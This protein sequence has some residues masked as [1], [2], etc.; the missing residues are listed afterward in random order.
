MPKHKL[1]HTLCSVHIELIPT[2]RTFMK[3]MNFHSSR[4]NLSYLALNY[5]S[6]FLTGKKLHNVQLQLKCHL[7]EKSSLYQ[8]QRIPS[9][10]LTQYFAYYILIF[11]VEEFSAPFPRYEMK[12][13]QEGHGTVLK[14]PNTFLKR[15]RY[16]ILFMFIYIIQPIRLPDLVSLIHTC[17]V[18]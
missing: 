18:N 15:I 6:T 10:A 13:L 7:H 5:C 3:V 16:N 8:M 12:P 17:F 1:L 4:F 11:T 14:P 2:S 9:S